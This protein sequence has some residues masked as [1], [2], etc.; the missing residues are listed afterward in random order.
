MTEAVS[1]GRLFVSY[2]HEDASGVADDVAALRARGFQIVSDED[3]A[4]GDDWRSHIAEA[5]M[6]ADAAVFFSSVHSNASRHCL[7]EIGFALDV[8]KPVVVVMLEDCLLAPGLR[9]YLGQQQ[10]LQRF[11]LGREEFLRG[12]ADA[13]AVAARGRTD[14]PPAGKLAFALALGAEDETSASTLRNIEHACH[15]AL[16]PLADV[17]QADEAGAGAT[18]LEISVATGDEG[19][20]IRVRVGTGPER[21]IH[22]PAD[23]PSALFSALFDALLDG[24][25]VETGQALPVDATDILQADTDDHAAFAAFLEGLAAGRGGDYVRALEHLRRAVELDPEFSLA[26]RAA[27]VSSQVLGDLPSQMAFIERA[28]DGLHR[29]SGDQRTRT[30]FLYH[31]MIGDH[32]RAIPELEQYLERHPRERGIADNLALSYLFTRDLDAAVEQGRR[33]AEH[34]HTF[35][36]QANLSMYLMYAGRFEEAEEALM[37]VDGPRDAYAL[38]STLAICRYAVGDAES[39]ETLFGT[40]RLGDPIRSRVGALG[41][42]AL[43]ASGGEPA[44]AV[45]ALLLDDDPEAPLMH[46]VEAWRGLHAAAAGAAGPGALRR[47]LPTVAGWGDGAPDLL[48]TPLQDGYLLARA[49]LSLGDHGVAARVAEAL[50]RHPHASATLFAMLLEGEASSLAGDHARA[51]ERLQEACERLDTWLGRYLL[52]RAWGE[53]GMRI[54]LRAAL[55]DC[56]QRR[57]EAMAVMLDELPTFHLDAEVRRLWEA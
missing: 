10:G 18:R 9:L 4:A 17:R 35:I 39:A 6:H 42:A 14:S 38:D 45:E 21:H 51:I 5:L 16:A 46:A 13:C 3:I 22:A 12:L 27:A 11:R 20:E 33:N 19:Q 54:E 40:M 34:H 55:D 8:E 56:L 36:T 49:A 24:L 53:A 7:A 2:S 43:R 57:G 15:W 32:R 52:A 41:L 25:A 50:H 48:A 1:A 31:M 29:L 44:A 26:A 23:P 37:N 47:Y 30:K 28:F